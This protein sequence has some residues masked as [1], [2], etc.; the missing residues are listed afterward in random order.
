[1]AVFRQLEAAVRAAAAR[2]AA[3]IVTVIVRTFMIRSGQA[4]EI[5]VEFPCTMTL[6]EAS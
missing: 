5:M 4:G 3:V 2:E 1:M 6:P